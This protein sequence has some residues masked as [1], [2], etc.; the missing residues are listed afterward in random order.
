[1]SVLRKTFI[2]LSNIVSIF[3][4][5]SAL[6]DRRLALGFALTTFLDIRII[7]IRLL[8]QRFLLT[9]LINF[10][11]ACSLAFGLSFTLSFCSLLLLHFLS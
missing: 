3:L 9:A 8:L 5:L 2:I 1:M 4:I 11:L 6:I 10:L 7:L